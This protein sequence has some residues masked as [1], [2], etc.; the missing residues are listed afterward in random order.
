MKAR[1]IGTQAL[2]E[3]ERKRERRRGKGRGERRKEGLAGMEW[4]RRAQVFRKGKRR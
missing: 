2:R 3:R 4:N 1:S